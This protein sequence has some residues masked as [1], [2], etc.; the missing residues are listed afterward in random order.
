[1]F[2]ERIVMWLKGHIVPQQITTNQATGRQQTMVSQQRE[3]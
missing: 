1:M 3:Q 2:Q